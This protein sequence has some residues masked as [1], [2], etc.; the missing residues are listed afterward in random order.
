VYTKSEY[1]TTTELKL[2]QSSAKGIWENLMINL[3]NQKQANVTRSYSSHLSFV[4]LF[5][6]IGEEVNTIIILWFVLHMQLTTK[7][8]CLFLSVY[9]FLKL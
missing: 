8:F 6:E 1:Q 2:Y 7:E 4:I 9:L 5:W 3:T